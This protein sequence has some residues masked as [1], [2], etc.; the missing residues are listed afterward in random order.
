V[1]DEEEEDNKSDCNG[2][3]VREGLIDEEFKRMDC[4][5]FHV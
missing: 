3:G 2:K 4:L 5:G 1:K